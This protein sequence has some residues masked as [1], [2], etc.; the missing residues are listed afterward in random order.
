MTARERGADMHDSPTTLSIVA[1]L[2]TTAQAAKIA[3]MGER[4]FWR[5]SHSGL[6]PAPIKIGGLT[7]YRRADVYAWISAG[8]PRCDGGQSHA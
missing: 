6:A 8:C 1:E 4:T 2:L 3:G 7:R 5:H